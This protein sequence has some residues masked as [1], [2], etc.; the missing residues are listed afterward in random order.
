MI[1][2]R[3]EREKEG[4]EEGREGGEG[5]GEG[6]IEHLLWY[7]PCEKSQIQRRSSINGKKEGK[8]RKEG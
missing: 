5:K 7:G 1:R 2:G 4:R 6:N 3:M 8:G